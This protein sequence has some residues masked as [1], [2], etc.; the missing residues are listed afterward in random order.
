MKHNDYTSL[1]NELVS[2]FDN[3]PSFAS[4]TEVRANIEE[5]RPPE[6]PKKTTDSRY[7]QYIKS[8]GMSSWELDAVIDTDV[9]E[10]RKLDIREK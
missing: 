5:L 6:N 8:Y 9:W 10:Q 1:V 4:E 7:K 3:L 2:I